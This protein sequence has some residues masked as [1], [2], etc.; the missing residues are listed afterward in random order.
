[1][2]WARLIQST[3]YHPISLSSILILLSL[4]VGLPSDLFPSA[5]P[6][7]PVCISPLLQLYQQH[8]YASLLSCIHHICLAPLILLDLVTWE[9]QTVKLLVVQFS[10]VPCYFFPLRIFLSL[11]ALTVTRFSLFHCADTCIH[12]CTLPKPPNV[13]G[14][15]PAHTCTDMFCVCAFDLNIEASPL[16][17][18]SSG[19]EIVLVHLVEI[20]FG[21]S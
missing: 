16:H 9:V 6:T 13:S 17:N 7:T 8:Q 3:P 1:M 15:V 5:V 18:Y 4:C 11:I 21:I 19:Y 14:T 10:P 20:V 2:S 12:L